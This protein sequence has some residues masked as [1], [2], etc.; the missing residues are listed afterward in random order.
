MPNI[1]IDLF[2]F[3]FGTLD[4]KG[5]IDHVFVLKSCFPAVKGNNMDLNILYWMY[6]YPCCLQVLTVPVTCFNS[7][8]Q[9]AEIKLLS[10]SCPDLPF[11]LLEDRH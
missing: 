6:S 7:R 9:R 11:S 4:N 2:F 10:E 5:K 3:Q 1:N 8:E